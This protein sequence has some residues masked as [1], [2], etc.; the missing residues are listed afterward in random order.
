MSKRGRD[1]DGGSKY[2]AAAR[3]RTED[4]DAKMRVARKYRDD[5]KQKTLDGHAGEEIDAARLAQD[6]RAFRRCTAIS[7]QELAVRLNLSIADI[8]MAENPTGRSAQQSV[9]PGHA[10]I[11]LR[12][13]LAKEVRTKTQGQRVLCVQ[14]E[15][16][17]VCRQVWSDKFY[18]TLP[19]GWGDDEEAGVSRTVAPDFS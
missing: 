15:P 5:G 13:Y 7:Q 16:L 11:R 2:D 9:L 8:T 17:R 6:L 19:D 4:L 14:F 10:K 12:E 3:K 1:Y 18:G